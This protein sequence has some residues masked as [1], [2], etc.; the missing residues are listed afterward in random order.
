MTSDA[1]LLRRLAEQ[2]PPSL[3]S[4]AE[5]AQLRQIARNVERREDEITRELPLPGPG[6]D[7]R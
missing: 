7:R 3:V 6:P 1:D 5:R 4:P 2:S